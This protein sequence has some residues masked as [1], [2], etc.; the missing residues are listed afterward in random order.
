MICPSSSSP[1]K[2]AFLCPI[3]LTFPHQHPTI[4]LPL[5]LP[6]P[7]PHHHTPSHTLPSPA[8]HHHSIHLPRTARGRRLTVSIPGTEHVNK[9]Q[10][11][12]VEKVGIIATRASGSSEHTNHQDNGMRINT[13]YHIRAASTPTCSEVSSSKGLC[14]SD[15]ISNRTI[16]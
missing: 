10:W 5:T 6:S 4:T 8:L 12:G 9:L 13:C 1:P 2:I 15:H 14:P 7:A 11:N 3:T 16:P